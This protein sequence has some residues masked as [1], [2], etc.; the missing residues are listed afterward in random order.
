MPMFTRRHYDAIARA[1]ACKL[2]PALKLMR[3]FRHGTELEK[4]MAKMLADLTIG[5]LMPMFRADNPNFSDDRF[6][7]AFLKYA[8]EE[9]DNAE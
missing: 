3:E 7:K 9:V 4:R 6:V 5:G 8:A 2:A 1:Q